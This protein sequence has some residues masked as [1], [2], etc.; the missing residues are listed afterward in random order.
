MSIALHVFNRHVFTTSI[1]VELTALCPSFAWALQSSNRIRMKE[2][3]TGLIS[4]V[5]REVCFSQSMTTLAVFDCGHTSITIGTPHP[6]EVTVLRE[7]GVDVTSNNKHVDKHCC[8][9]GTWF[10]ELRLDPLRRW[11]VLELVH[12][13]E[14][15][16]C[17][18]LKPMKSPGS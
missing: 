15:S 13:F 9:L 4:K 3:T 7:K 8:C 10:G 18:C 11:T 2:N 6:H 17:L 12:M 14:G 16:T 5:F 1:A